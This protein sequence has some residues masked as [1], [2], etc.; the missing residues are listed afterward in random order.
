MWHYR[1]EALVSMSLASMT[2]AMLTTEH[3]RFQFSFQH[4]SLSFALSD[5][6]ETGLILASVSWNQA[7]AAVCGTFGPLTKLLFAR[8]KHYSPI[9]CKVN[10]VISK[11]FDIC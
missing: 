2:R 11:W 7:Y 8:P 4:Q 3:V 1:R 10:A 6:F 9:H 5:V